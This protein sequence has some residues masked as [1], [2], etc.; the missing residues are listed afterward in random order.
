MRALFAIIF[1]AVTYSAF[2]QNYFLKGEILDEKAQPMSSAAAVL[3][4]PADSTLLYFSITGGNGSFEMR[5]IKKGSYLLQVSL[6][7]YNTFY[8]SVEIPSQEGED[9]GQIM[10]VPK[11]YNINE[12]TINADRIPM[13]IKQDTIE[14]DAKAFK[15]KADGVAEDLIRKL[16]GVE[17]DRAGNIKALGEDVNNVLVDGKEF[18]GNDPKVATRNLP[19][20]AIDKVQLYDKQTDESEFTGI[21]DGERN[22]TL[23]LVL[24][25]NKKQGVFGDVMGGAGT[26]ERAQAAAKIYRFT[27]KSQFAGIGMF[28]NINQLGFSLGDY[29]NFSGGM[30]SFSSGDGHFIIGG[31]NSF[32][33]NFGQPVYGKG[34]NGAAGMNFSIFKGKDRFFMSYLGNGSRRI[35]PETSKTRSYLPGSSFLTDERKEQLKSDTTHR[36]NFGARKLIGEKQN[37][38]VNGV[39][40]YNSSSNPLF[41]SSES[42]YG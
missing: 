26:D 40:S 5:N 16:P 34:S 30:S 28:N 21:D 18:F 3:L 37:I 41:S 27:K 39:L 4:N 32:P 33:V 8:H 22:Q 9:L 10:M 38:I 17:V 35:I 20:N 23:N 31:E 36:L 19:A 25:K 1:T 29:I 2:G 6:M 11:V 24:D 12:V 15:V 7:G 13:R 14:Y 42:F